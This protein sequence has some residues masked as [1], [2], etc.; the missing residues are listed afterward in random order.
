LKEL[1]AMMTAE[2]NKAGRNAAAIELSCMGRAKLDM[3]K[4]VQDVGVSRV[5]VAPP[6]FDKEGLTRGLETMANE[7]LAKL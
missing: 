5:V 2:A 7:V 6:G 3:I 4:A 1:F